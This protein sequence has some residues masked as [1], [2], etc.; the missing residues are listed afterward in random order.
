MAYGID[1]QCCTCA[2]ASGRLGERRLELQASS[3]S[4]PARRWAGRLLASGRLPLRGRILARAPQVSTSA[5]FKTANKHSTLAGWTEMLEPPPSAQTS[6]LDS[7]FCRRTGIYQLGRQRHVR[8]RPAALTAAAP[9][10]YIQPGWPAAAAVAGA[11]HV[12]QP[13][14]LAGGG[15]RRSAAPIWRG[16]PG[17]ACLWRRHVF[18]LHGCINLRTQQCHRLLTVG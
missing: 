11:G 1:K 9:P 17:E 10:A 16:W 5:V 7:C 4:S 2:Q 3:S 13:A 15:G 6:S 8:R 18:D 14:G 12:W